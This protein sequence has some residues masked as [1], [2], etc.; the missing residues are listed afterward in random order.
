MIET[1]IPLGSGDAPIPGGIVTNGTL[2]D[3]Q[4]RWAGGNLVRFQNGVPSPLGG[5]STLSLSATPPSGGTPGGAF[6]WTTS[7]GST[8]VACGKGNKLY[9]FARQGTP[10]HTMTD[11]TPAGILNLNTTTNGWSFANL[12]DTLLASRNGAVGDKLWS[13]DPNIGGVA[14]VPNNSPSSVRGVF[15][16]PE[17][18]VVVITGARDIKWASQATLTTWT[19]TSTNSA[20]GLTIPS[21][22]SLTVG[23]KV[24]N[25]SILCTEDDT[26]SLDYI[27]ASLYYGSTLI[28]AGK[29]IIGPNT[30]AIVGDTAYWMGFG[31][32]YK[33]DGY[34]QQLRCDIG[35]TIYVQALAKAYGP[36][37]FAI[38]N[39]S[40]S[41]IWWFYCSTSSAVTPD[42]MAIYNY[43]QDVWSPGVLARAAGCDAIWHDAGTAENVSPIL[44]DA[45]GTTVYQ[46]E[47]GQVATGAYIESGPYQMDSGKNTVLVSKFIPDAVAALLA[48]DVTLFSGTFPGIAETSN[49]PYST[50]IGP[51]DTRFRARWVRYKQTL[52]S[53]TS[54]TG[55]PRLGI[56]PSS[57]R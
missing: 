11:I 25:Q 26:W 3:R 43:A 17:Q 24:R 23:R 30:L 56:I 46:H 39:S 51:I 36:R 5:W 35:D 29:G 50:N 4:G 14:T 21:A 6:A 8:Y 55:I 27:G 18:F 42:Q 16:T 54:R 57:G 37:F 32:F 20:G 52:K 48:D 15:V 47:N 9:V 2:F 13:W 49:G 10:P 45:D 34:V 28:G 31:G 19:P 1:V 7:A 41:E 33:Y 40:A 44:F 53:T 38:I 12:G 22:S